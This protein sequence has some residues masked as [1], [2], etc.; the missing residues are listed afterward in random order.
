MKHWGCEYF[1]D[2]GIMDRSS[3][4]FILLYYRKGKTFRVYA[5]D[6]PREQRTSIVVKFNPLGRKDPYLDDVRSCV[7]VSV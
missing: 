7:C 1:L 2:F 5:V 6:M 3:Y 4:I